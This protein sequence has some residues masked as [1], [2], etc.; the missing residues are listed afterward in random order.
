MSIPTL[1]KSVNVTGTDGSRDEETHWAPRPRKPGPS[2]LVE[3]P[4]TPY[5][6]CALPDPGERRLHCG[7]LEYDQAIRYDGSVEALRRVED[8]DIQVAPRTTRASCPGRP[9]SQGYLATTIAQHHRQSRRTSGEART[10][11]PVYLLRK[12]REPDNGVRQPC[13]G[14]HS[15]FE[16]FD[17]H[18]LRRACVR[19]FGCSG[20]SK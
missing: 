9:G 15:S 2:V 17:Q 20:Q 13:R 12:C 16:V 7:S 14:G 8:E 18:E 6:S 1:D 10:F 11:E 5:A 4:S 19:D 3:S